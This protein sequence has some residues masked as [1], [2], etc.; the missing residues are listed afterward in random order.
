[1]LIDGCIGRNLWG[2][3]GYEVLRKVTCVK[4]AVN[5]TR[6]GPQPLIPNN[7]T[8]MAPLNDKYPGQWY[9]EF[10]KPLILCFVIS[11]PVYLAESH[12]GFRK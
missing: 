8:G 6:V 10:L 1:M 9:L 5:A 3:D 12:Q 4:Y 7:K 2:M 11:P